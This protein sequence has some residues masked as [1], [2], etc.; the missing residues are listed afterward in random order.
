MSARPLSRPLSRPVSR[1][2]LLAGAAAGSLTAAA[3]LVPRPLRAAPAAAPARIAMILWRGE[4]GT[5]A[6]FRAELADAR[7]AADI[8]VFNLDR[9]L[10]RL[11]ATLAEI[12]DMAPDLVYTWGTGITLGTVGTW[13][14]A[15]PATTIADRPVVF[16]M[17]SAPWRTGIAA[18]PGQARALVTGTSHI[19][20]LASQIGAMRAYLPMQRLGVVYNPAEPNSVANV[21]ELKELSATLDFV[22]E[23]A[24]VPAAAD[25]GDPDPAAIPGLVATL[26]ERGAQV[27]YIG[28]DNFIGTNRQALT[29]A[30]FSHGLPAFTATELEI[31][32]GDALIGLVSRYEQVGRLAARKALAILRDG[33][34]PSAIPVETLERF[35][36][37]VN[38]RAARRLSLWPPLPLLDYA[39]VIT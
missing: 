10:S 2:A 5:E 14:A 6:G 34:P 1:R 26:A 36:Y 8:T 16:T 25:G 4:T 35:S 29:E 27:L 19:A 13:D 38:M 33:Q 32:D 22:V 21:A 24:P 3:G 12:R 20:P 39:E 23:P 31:R 18:P 30:G 28:P 11:P 9:D 17:V 7:F 37:I 15:D